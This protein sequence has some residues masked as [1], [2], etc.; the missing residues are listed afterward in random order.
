MSK[1][2]LEALKEIKI[3]L[4]NV[5]VKT[6]GEL[7]YKLNPK[8]YEL[9]QILETALKHLESIDN[10]K[11]SEGL[12]KLEELKYNIQ[13]EIRYHYSGYACCKEE[14]HKYDDDFKVIERALLDKQ[15][16][17]RSE[18]ILQKYYQEGITLDSVRTLKQEKDNYKKVFKIVFKKNVDMLLIK[19]YDNVSDYNSAVWLSG[20]E[21]LTEEEFNLLKGILNDEQ[22]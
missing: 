9:C 3:G 8:N 21:K 14:T 4:S 5:S 22:V 18:E 15:D 16:N 13:D 12:N 7:V 1:E 20:R 17:A 10:S 6:N 11:P 2:Y 19:K